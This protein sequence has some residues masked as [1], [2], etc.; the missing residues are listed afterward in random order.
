MKND[1]AKQFEI[2]ANQSILI[3]RLARPFLSMSKVQLTFRSA[4]WNH[5]GKV[6]EY[7]LMYLTSILIARGLGVAENGRFVGLFSLSQLMLVLCS[8][9]LETSLN[10]FIPQLEQ[11]SQVEQTRYMLRRMALIRGGACLGVSL[12]LIVVLLMVPGLSSEPRSVL[13]IVLLFS[14]VRSFFP[15]FAMALTAQLRTA[16]TAK[17]NVAV[18][19]IEACAAALMVNF[20]MSV[21]SLF[22]L[23][24]S[25]ST[26]HVL[27][28]VLFSRTN[29]IGNASPVEMNPIIRFGG[30]FWINAIAD[31]FLGRQGDVLFLKNM[32]SDPTPAS[33]YDVAF[34]LAQLVALGMTV[35]LSGVTF[36]TFARL[37]VTSASAVDRFYAFSIRGISLLTIPF[38]AFLLFNADT[39]LTVLYS[40]KYRAAVPLLQG[41]LMFRILCRLFGG[42]ENA[43]YLLSHGRVVGVVTI[44]G[45][46]AFV[47]VALNLALIPHMQAGGSVIASGCANVLANGLGALMV[48]KM[49]T[50]RIQIGF[51]V[52]LT[53]VSL[54][55]AFLSSMI[56]GGGGI[57]HLVLA[58]LLYTAMMAVALVLLKPFTALDR[59]WLIQLDERIS[60][61]LLIAA[62]RGKARVAE[63]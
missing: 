54:V 24:L 26:L 27:L 29:L 14:T 55:A 61:F 15:L 2:P 41:I 58:A 63:N 21:E 52:K 3:H 49:S 22:V 45:V 12:L 50:N 36:A 19:M 47:N 33:L 34:S 20:G 11:G 18:R 38:F 42:A 28:Y 60:R 48:A 46:A 5:A 31:F 53:A 1:D 39:V 32:L 59:D 62:E 43:E 7:V 9:G 40:E 35:G 13:L 56:G 25:T 57:S 51:W 6:L 23:F 37:A 17:I 16:L 10:K 8:F 4:L 44:S 30:I